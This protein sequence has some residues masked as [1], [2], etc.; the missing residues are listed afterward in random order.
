MRI[1]ILNGT[2]CCD[3][4]SVILHRLCGDREGQ[5]RWDHLQGQ[6]AIWI[7]EQGADRSFLFTKD[8]FEKVK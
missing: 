5:L 1:T 8:I 3:G 4:D 2:P 6:F 7:N